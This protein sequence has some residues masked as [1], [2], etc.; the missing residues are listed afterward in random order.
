MARI[1]PFRGWRYN[2][3]NVVDIH[4]KFSPLFDVVSK[5]QLAELYTIPNN[6]IF[7]SV[8]RTHDEAVYKLKEWKEKSILK[9]EALPSIYPY[10]LK[11]SLCIY[12]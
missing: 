1:I 8:P 6:S 11:F 12:L 7:L 5:E 4:K 10:F 3:E 2:V 9:Q